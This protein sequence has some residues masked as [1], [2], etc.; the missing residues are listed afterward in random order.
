[1]KQAAGRKRGRLDETPRIAWLSDRLD[2]LS[3]ELDGN[4]DAA[5]AYGGRSPFSRAR[6]WVLAGAILLG[7]LVAPGTATAA[8]PFGTQQILDQAEA[9]VTQATSQISQAAA[10]TTAQVSPANAAATVPQGP[11]K[12]WSSAQPTSSSAGA[13][14]PLAQVEAGVADAVK[15]ATTVASRVGLAVSEAQSPTAA[16]AQPAPRVAAPKARHSKPREKESTVRPALPRSSAHPSL[17]IVATSRVALPTSAHVRRTDTRQS[18]KKVAGA[19]PQRLPPLP[20]PPRPDTTSS[21]QGGGG[22]GPSVQLVVG[23][24]AAMLLLLGFQLLPRLLPRTAFR[25]PRRI[26]LSPWH[27]G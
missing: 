11:A 3:A 10:Q 16:P 12:S 4:R 20:L 6:A 23:A 24:L 22:Q 9:A 26:A 2:D 5:T 1:M 7:V 18:P 17:R 21:G 27:P 19:V 13:A 15:E 8:D 14:Q 25:K